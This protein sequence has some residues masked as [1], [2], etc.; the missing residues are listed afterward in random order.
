MAQPD[1]KQHWLK[2][3]QMHL[4]HFKENVLSK[5]SNPAYILESETKITAIPRIHATA[6]LPLPCYSLVNWK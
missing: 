1:D 3:T 6:S 4:E 2:K 5:F